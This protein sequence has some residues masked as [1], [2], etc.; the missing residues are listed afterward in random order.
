M[1]N[2]RRTIMGACEYSIATLTNLKKDL[3]DRDSKHAEL[4]WAIGGI[5]VTL[6]SQLL[7]ICDSVFVEAAQAGEP[8]AKQDLSEIQERFNKLIE[9]MIDND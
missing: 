5:V 9:R 2:Q 1:S 6:V 8:N 7:Q 3:S 4:N